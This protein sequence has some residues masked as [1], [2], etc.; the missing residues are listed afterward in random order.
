MQ[1]TINDILQA[2][3]TTRLKAYRALVAEGKIDRDTANHRY[4]CIQTAL[5]MAGGSEKPA[6]AAT[7]E[8]ARAE[9]LR[10]LKE[11]QRNSTAATMHADGRVVALLN[12]F[13]EKTKNITPVPVQTS[14]I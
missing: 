12:E 1:Y 14:L 13:L 9:I 5:W 6:T 3:L 10:W 4:L 2:E 8:D 11:I 7:A